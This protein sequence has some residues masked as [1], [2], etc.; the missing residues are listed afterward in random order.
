MKITPGKVVGWTVSAALLI[1]AI[2][3]VSPFL[4]IDASDYDKMSENG[5]RLAI[6]LM[7]FIIFLGKWAFDVFAPQGLAKRVSGIGTVLLIVGN[8][9]LVSFI[10]FIVAQA[11]ALFLRSAVPQDAVNF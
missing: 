2:W 9:A 6:G 3:L 4:K 8:L 10:I 7:I 11:A 5:L 1:F